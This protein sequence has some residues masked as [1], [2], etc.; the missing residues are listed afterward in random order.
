MKISELISRLE[1]I[2]SEE[3]DLLVVSYFEG[4]FPHPESWQETD[5]YEI[6]LIEIEYKWDRRRKAFCSDIFVRKGTQSEVISN[7]KFADKFTS[8]GLPQ[9]FKAISFF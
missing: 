5:E 4:I 1:K 7:S 6:N 9:A 3:G 8:P 2:K